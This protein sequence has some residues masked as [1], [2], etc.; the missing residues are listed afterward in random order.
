MEPFPLFFW[1][2]YILVVV[3]YVSKWVEVVSTWTIETRVV[4]KF[5]R[6]DI[7]FRYGMPTAIISDQGTH[8]DN[9]SFNTLLKKYSIIYC[10]ATFYHP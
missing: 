1:N 2:E 6:E 4:I 7:F 8:F 5:L 9:R 3:D 10:L